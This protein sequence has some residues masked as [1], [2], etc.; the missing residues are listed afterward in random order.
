MHTYKR[1]WAD[2]PSVD[3]RSLRLRCIKTLVF[4]ITLP[5]AVRLSSTTSDSA[6]G[7]SA[8]EAVVSCGA[9]PL[10]PVVGD[11]ML[12]RATSRSM[13]S[14]ASRSTR[15]SLVSELSW[16]RAV[17]RSVSSWKTDSEDADRLFSSGLSWTGD[18]TLR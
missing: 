4:H 5:G 16:E 17:L 15:M 11:E 8:T 9:S 1:F 10:P 12:A 3:S 7:S 13:D 18:S 6:L 2:L 14:S